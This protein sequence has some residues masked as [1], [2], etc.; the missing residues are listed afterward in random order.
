MLLGIEQNKVEPVICKY[1]Y[2]DDKKNQICIC[3]YEIM[4]I[5]KKKHIVE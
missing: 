4:L 5:C 1:Y 2:T 3:L